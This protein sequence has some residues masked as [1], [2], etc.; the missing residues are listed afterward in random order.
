MILLA[1]DSSTEHGGIAL[2]RDGEVTETI[3][4]SPDGFAH[5]LFVEL[6]RL[7][8]QCGVDLTHI[9]AF[10][11]ASGPGSFT[12]VRVALSAAK[13]FGEA[14]GKPVFAISNLRAMAAHGSAPIRAAILDARRGEIYGGLYDAALQPLREEAVMLLQ[15]WLDS[16]PATFPAPTVELLCP[17]PERFPELSARRV[18]TAPHAVARAVAHLAAEQYRAGERPHPAASDANYVRR[19]DAELNWREA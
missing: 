8:A 1:I 18:T 2:W 17:Y 15:P 5:V 7:L 16:L 3:V 6:E 19:S 10:A 13:G 4:H 12:G 14:F 11:A 9:D